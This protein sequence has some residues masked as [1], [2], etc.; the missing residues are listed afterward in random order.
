MNSRGVGP[1]RSIE[2]LAE[3][4]TPATQ[5]RHRR[6]AP[7]P[8]RR[9]AS[10][11]SSPRSIPPSSIRSER[12]TCR[13]RRT[14]LRTIASAPREIQAAVWKKLKPKKGDGANWWKIAQALEKTRFFAEDAKFGEE[15]TGV[16][17]A[18]PG[19][20]TCSLRVTR[21]I[22]S[23]STAKPSVGATRLARRQYAEERRL[24][25]D[26]PAYGQPKLPPKAQ[27]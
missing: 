15:R 13:R 7:V 6:R 11:A 17:L 21:T 5:R 12:A 27:S 9:S 24:A 19:R 20:K 23:P 18:S 1:W 3:N 8:V 16:P 4:W 2:S 26:R 25:G 22:A 10:S 14:T